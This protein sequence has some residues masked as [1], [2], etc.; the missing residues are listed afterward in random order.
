MV[1]GLDL[2]LLNTSRAGPLRCPIAGAVETGAR[3]FAELDDL[4][5]AA[6]E[7]PSAEEE[8]AA[9][10]PQSV[11]RSA[12]EFHGRGRVV[13]LSCG[14][15]LGKGEQPIM[16]SQF[17]MELRGLKTVDGEDPPHILH[18][19]PR[20]RGDW[21]SR[22]VIEQNTCY[23]M[24]WGAPLRCEGWKSHSDEETGWG[25]LQFQFDYFEN[26]ILD[27]DGRSKESTTTWLNRLI[28]QKEMNFDWPYPFV[29]GRLFVLT[30]SAGLEGGFVLEDATGLSLSGDLDVQSGPYPLHTQALPQSYL[31]M[32]T[33]WQSSPLP[34]E[35][36]DIFIGILSS[37]NHFAERMGVRKT[38]MS[39]VRNSPKC[40]QGTKVAEALYIGNINF[41]HRSLRHGKWAVTYE[42]W[43]EEVY[44]PYANG[45]GYVISSDIAG[46]IVSEFRDRKLRSDRRRAAFVQVTS[47]VV[48]PRRQ[49][50][51]CRD[52]HLPD[53]DDNG[54]VPARDPSLI[55]GK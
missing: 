13:E 16:V 8:E 7:S 33:V 23:R 48:A 42:E 44:P 50:D 3:V 40:Q 34:N 15:T 6:F 9:K 17:M 22:P 32:S 2:G 1:S 35:P 46:A 12:D 52:W 30:I 38:W 20:L 49:F 19:N 53:A 55:L 43:P 14:L 31:D 47:S 27:A 51:A 28:G 41:H 10:C 37:G 21:S 29:E 39:A 26:W 18:F 36:V 4:D 25:P 45:P 5:T 54:C 11:M 24:Q